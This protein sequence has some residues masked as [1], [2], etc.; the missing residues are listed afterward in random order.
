MP[1]LREEGY[2]WVRVQFAICD[3]GGIIDE[4][5]GLPEIARWQNLRWWTAGSQFEVPDQFAVEVLSERLR[6]A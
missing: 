2:Y 4:K 3:S 6:L 1:E 5:W